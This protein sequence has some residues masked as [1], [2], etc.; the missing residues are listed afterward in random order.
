MSFFDFS[1][2]YQKIIVLIAF[3]S[4]VSTASARWTF[5]LFSD[6]RVSSICV[7]KSVN[8]LQYSLAEAKSIV[9]LTGAGMSAESGIPAFRDAQNGLWSQFDPTQLASAEAYRGGK[10][11]ASGWYVWRMAMVR[12]AAACGS[13]RTGVAGGAEA[14]HDRGDTECR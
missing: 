6:F 9:I 13:S 3:I 1:N 10:A 11:L 7:K 8:L 14:G 4:T 2:V 5:M 12:G